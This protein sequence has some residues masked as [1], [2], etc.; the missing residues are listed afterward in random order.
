[1]A[2][3][4]ASLLAAG[5][6]AAV[7]FTTVPAYAAAPPTTVTN[8][9]AIPGDS[10]VKLTWTNPADPDF[11]G[12]T[13]IRK[14]GATPPATVTDGDTHY[15]G[16]AS[17]TTVFGLS[18][19]ATYSFA[20]F[21]RNTAGDLSDPA[22]VSKAPIP[23]LATTLVATLTPG[24]VTYG[25]GV[26]ITGTLKRT[27][28]GAVLA[29]EPVDFYRKTAGQADFVKLGRLTTNAAGTVTYKP[30]PPTVNT[31]W[32]LA[33]PASA[34]VGSSKSA[35]LVSNV[36]PRL[37]VRV[38]AYTVEQGVA[39]V[40]TVL[41]SPN[42]AGQPMLLQLWTSEGW[43]T[44]ASRTINAS[45]VARFD[46]ATNT[47][48]TRVFRLAKNADADHV[49]TVTTAFGIRVVKRTL[50][51]GMSGPDVLA[52]QKRLAALRYDVGTVNGFFGYD[53]VHATA[54][55]QKTQGLPRT[56]AVD[57]RTLDRL[58]R[59]AAITLRYRHSGAWVEADLTK[60]VL[61]YVRDG[62]IQR[63]LDVSSGNGETFY[64]EGTT[65][66]AVT[67]LGNFR[68]LRKIDGWRISRLG[69]LWRP[70]Y[71]ASGGFAIHGAPSV[72]FYPA[73]HGCIRITIPAM[74]RLFAMLPV[75][76]PV[77]VYK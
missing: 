73:S 23:A 43:K 12:V 50:R 27:D 22:V 52:V 59:P 57:A 25:Q 17:T 36:R 58:Q 51:A 44:V 14:D 29:G 45:S 70:A 68:V 71:F 39:S 66:R 54:A 33:H 30:M 72:P 15:T 55:F 76:L 24:V 32:Y 2:R 8:L 75:G 18:N 16:V 63:I 74:N 62:V 69:S 26:T 10:Q 6:S 61:Y 40:V 7:L 53:T 5:L 28:T 42:H 47:L 60:Q 19:G 49:A 35:T 1:M 65:Q 13:V 56:G 21:T 64:V 11:A 38:S 46:I 48:G 20:V 4:T 9:D 31:Q 41:V 67:P 37:G 77:H 34:Y 3:V